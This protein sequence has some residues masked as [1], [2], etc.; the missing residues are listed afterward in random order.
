MNRA[1][2]GEGRDDIH[3]LSAKDQSLLNGRDTFFF[4]DSFFD[5]VDLNWFSEIFFFAGLR[6]LIVGVG[7]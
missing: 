7:R 1:R 3:L 5:S 6:C 4:F 2:T